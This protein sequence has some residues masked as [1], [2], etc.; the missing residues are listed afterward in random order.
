MVDREGLAIK[1]VSRLSHKRKGPVASQ[2]LRLRYGLIG[3][4]CVAALED[5]VAGREEQRRPRPGRSSLARASQVMPALPAELVPVECERPP[6][7]VAR[8]HR[9]GA[10]AGL[11]RVSLAHGDKATARARSDRGRA[12]RDRQGR[13]GH[14]KRFG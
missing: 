7:T 13:A 1:V 3:R 9:D 10:G 2:V 8:A 12:A 14:L 5:V 4:Q 6:D 11:G